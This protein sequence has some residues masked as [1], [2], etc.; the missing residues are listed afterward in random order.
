M[1]PSGLFLSPLLCSKKASQ[2]ILVSAL[3]K[4]VLARSALEGEKVEAG[5]R[6]RRG[7][8]PR[9]LDNGIFSPPS[10]L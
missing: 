10:L 5:F 4:L 3:A 7:S 8:D 2:S 1:V 6:G 9:T